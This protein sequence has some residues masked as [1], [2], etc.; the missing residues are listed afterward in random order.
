MHNVMQYSGKLAQ[1]EG[2]CKI[3]HVVQQANISHGEIK[4]NKN[5]KILN[6]YVGR[7]PRFG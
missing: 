4:L 2:C 6:N 3:T 7:V 5:R 1:K